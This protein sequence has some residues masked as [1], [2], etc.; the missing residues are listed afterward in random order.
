M[1]I[2]ERGKEKAGEKRRD[3]TGANK[4]EQSLTLPF[5][6]SLIFMDLRTAGPRPLNFSMIASVVANL[7]G[8]MTGG[9]HLF[10]RS[11]CLSTFGQNKCDAHRDKL[12]ADIRVQTSDGFGYGDRTNGRP[13][14]RRSG[15]E[16]RNT[17]SSSMYGKEEEERI[18]SPAGTPTYDGPNPLRSHLIPPAATLAPPQA[19][20]LRPPSAFQALKAHIRKSSQSLFTR[21]NATKSFTLLPATTYSPNPAKQAGKEDDIQF[22][23]PPPLVHGDGLRHRRDSSIAS[24]TTVQIGLRFSNVED[25]PPLGSPFYRDS[26]EVYNLGCPNERSDGKRPSPL[27]AAENMGNDDED[28]LVAP[29]RN[30]ADAKPSSPVT[31]HYSKSQKNGGDDQELTLTSAVYTPSPTKTRVTSPLGVGFGTTPRAKSPES[32]SR[33]KCFKSDCQCDGLHRKDWI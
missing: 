6:Y 22:L 31:E 32:T 7:S 4:N 23:V 25:A 17:A 10:L 21:D 16:R 33:P 19:T 18:E 14:T 2:N 28:T 11:N 13:D 12:K 15:R 29:P 27:A 9:L 5:F 24:H 3:W 26:G 30:F 1:K 20:E 8:L